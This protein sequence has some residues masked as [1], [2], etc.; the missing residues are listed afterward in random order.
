MG[1][2]LP[3]SEA[4]D[5]EDEVME[6]KLPLV[7]GIPVATWESLRVLRDSKHAS[8]NDWLD[9][10]TWIGEARDEKRGAGN[11]REEKEGRTTGLWEIGTYDRRKVGHVLDDI[12][13][14][15]RNMMKLESMVQVGDAQTAW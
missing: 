3:E 1:L 6:D 2:E 12:L 13:H 14:N 10:E 4:G 9:G 8:T 11:P 7:Q 5:D 15:G